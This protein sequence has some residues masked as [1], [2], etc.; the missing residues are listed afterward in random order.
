MTTA[1]RTRDFRLRSAWFV[2]AGFALILLFLVACVAAFERMTGNSDRTFLGSLVF[3]IVD[4]ARGFA[5]HPIELTLS[6]LGIAA[7]VEA[8]H[9]AVA[10]LLMPWGAKDEPLRA[11]WANSVRQVWFR[12][13]QVIPCT[14]IVGTIA[15][16][17]DVANERYK[18]DHPQPQMATSYPTY[19]SISPTDPA[20]PAA[21]AAFNAAQQKWTKDNAVWFEQWRAWKAAQPWYL[22]DSE[23]LIVCSVFCCIGWIVWGLLRAIGAPRIVTPGEHPPLCL[24]CGYNLTSLPMEGRCPECGEDVVDSLGPDAQPGAEWERGSTV[25]RTRTWFRT[26]RDML[27]DPAGFG[28]RLRVLE[29]GTAHRSYLPRP[30]AF[31]FFL[32]GTALMMVIFWTGGV[33]E[34]VERPAISIA[35]FLIS[36]TVCSLG[37][38]L[39]CHLGALVIGLRH[40]LMQKRN[41]LPASMQVSTYLSGYL[42]LWAFFGACLILILVGMD[43]GDWFD[44]LEYLTGLPEPFLVFL[45]F[46]A[47]N[48]AALGLF[49]IVLD[50]CVRGARFANR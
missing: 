30:A 39:M 38:V 16:T 3:I 9:L 45:S 6:I 43:K 25:A 4:I 22:H 48:V 17:L 26:A 34:L 35:A 33:D 14:L 19:P 42:A 12:T 27:R 11:S 8:V 1:H 10:L 50:K 31:I 37:S 24:F 5:E 28:R 46:L 23:P 49:L 40:S 41:L 29:A 20:Y 2:H 15:A 44:G 36:G 47:P 18:R 21:M 13:A 32:A 7:A